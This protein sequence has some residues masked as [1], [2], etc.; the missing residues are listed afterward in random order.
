MLESRRK[1]KRF[2][3]PLFASFRPTYGATEYSVGLIKNFSCEGLAIEVNNFTFI[4]YENLELN[5]RFPHSDAFVFLSGNVAWKKQSSNNCLAGV[6]L[7]INNEENRLHLLKNISSFANI[8]L[9]SLTV[10]DNS[11][12]VISGTRAGTG[13]QPARKKRRSS[14][15]TRRIG[16]S[17]QYCGG[18][19]KCMV[20]FRLPKEAA[21]DAQEVTIAG[22]FNDWNPQNTRMKRLSGGDFHIT[23]ELLSKRSYRFRY[24]IDGHQWENDW[25]ADKY[26]PNDFG[27]DDSVVIV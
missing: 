1:F 4:Q 20:T 23:L 19:S 24:L 15:K 18:G 8:P 22:D 9:N 5:L 27:S 17:R 25:R 6:K 26:V 7:K 14:R 21:P 11:Y 13:P 10:K 12:E 2:D 3:L 16:I